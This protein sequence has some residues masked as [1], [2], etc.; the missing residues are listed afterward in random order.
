[1]IGKRDITTLEK[2]LEKSF[3][4]WLMTDGYGAYRWYQKRL[5]CRA[6]LKRKAQGLSESLNNEARSFGKKGPEPSNYFD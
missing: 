3:S 5:R 4:G 2:I 6:H 1:M